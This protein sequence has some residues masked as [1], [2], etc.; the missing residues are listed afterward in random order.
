MS[1][2]RPSRLARIATGWPPWRSI[3]S[4][5]RAVRVGGGWATY[6]NRMTKR[7]PDPGTGAPRVR[8]ALTV[9]RDGS[10]SGTVASVS[11]AG[12]IDCGSKCTF[13]FVSGTN[14][15]LAATPAQ[16]S[17]FA[18]WSGACTGAESCPVLLSGPGPGPFVEA[19]F[20]GPR[21]L[22]VQVTSV[23]GGRGSASVS[24]APLGPVS[25]C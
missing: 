9:T 14:V 13:N 11:L 7:W 23:E 1:I 8:S 5:K 20:L 10:G 24:P 2:H 15:T 21:T 25:L 18:G 16:G 22:T 19:S 6:S 12:A 4:K 17:V 3:A